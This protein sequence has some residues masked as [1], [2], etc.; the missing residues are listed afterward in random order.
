MSSSGYPQHHDGSRGNWQSQQQPQQIRTSPYH[1]VVGQPPDGGASGSTNSTSNS[2][3]SYSPPSYAQQHQPYHPHHA[4]THGQPVR[5]N[6]HFPSSINQHTS[7]N[8]QQQ[9]QQQAQLQH[10]YAQ[11]RPQ[12]VVQAA[13][14]LPYPAHDTQP[15]SYNNNRDP[16]QTYQPSYAQQSLFQPSNSPSNHHQ[17]QQH[18]ASPSHNLYLASSYPQAS[19]LNTSSTGNN[20]HCTTTATAAAGLHPLLAGRRT[21]TYL[22]AS[23]QGGNQEQ[24]QLHH[25]RQDTDD[26]LMD[27]FKDP[28]IGALEHDEIVSG[29]PLPLEHPWLDEFSLAV[30]EIALEPM[31]GRQLH[32]RIESQLEAIERN[33]IPCVQ[34]L[35]QCQQELR[36]A[37]QL[38]NSV[39]SQRKKL[40]SLPKFHQLFVQTLPNKF[41]H[42]QSW[43]NKSRNPQ[44][45]QERNL[46][47]QELKQLSNDA[48]KVAE[49]SEAQLS[50]NY[51]SVKAA[52]LGG[53]REGE[54][55]GLRKWL[56]KHG[57]GLQICTDLECILRALND[58]DN[59][60]N[61]NKLAHLFRPSTQHTL[62]QL[63]RDIPSSYQERSAAHPYLPF[64]HRMEEALRRLSTFDPHDDG[65]ICLV[66]SDDDSP[67]VVEETPSN[68]GVSVRK[69]HAAGDDN[70]KKKR[71]VEMFHLDDC[72][73][74][75]DSN[76]DPQILNG[77]SA[78][79]RYSETDGSSSSG[80]SEDEKVE[81][82]HQAESQKDSNEIFNRRNFHQVGD[83]VHD[84]NSNNSSPWSSLG[85]EKAPP[86]SVPLVW[87]VA[88]DALNHAEKLAHC[89]DY[90]A[91]CF[92]SGKQQTV[93]PVTAPFDRFWDGRNYATIMRLLS[94]ILRHPNV[95]VFV[96][97]IQ[98]EWLK[99]DG[100]PPFSKRVEHPISLSQ[101]VN[102]LA[103]NPA[104]IPSIVCN[105]GSLPI[106]TL[107]SWN[108]WR[109]KDLIMAVDLVFLNFL[110]YSYLLGEERTEIRSDANKMRLILWNGVD[111][112]IDRCRGDELW[113]YDVMPVKR[114]F[115][116]GFVISKSSQ[117]H[118]DGLH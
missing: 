14:I 31:T 63:R 111:S 13:S 101:V 33:Y 42:K 23:S 69:R 57:K 85:D 29:P 28:V 1:T 7:P 51:E 90:I 16:H 37:V 113:R 5:I 60:V 84:G 40:M 4:L 62:H 109:G 3:I 43:S 61:V 89:L 47:F 21:P 24:Q 98:D 27:L 32:Q 70:P 107:S 75:P 2:R 77:D 114:K 93:R 41:Y 18:Y 112:I 95:G 35:V 91:G 96:N 49:T 81:I 20:I 99:R 97:P 73:P 56:S 79:R 103:T 17:Q 117:G 52:F 116:S 110:G 72:E 92:D 65:V 66:D 83:I 82:I 78:S 53:M 55:W 6:H 58:K 67:Q 15:H 94:Q 38:S 64:F 50:R 104:E 34:F 68:P 22:F 100:Y 108:M 115:T 46:A 105:D 71:S 59:K 54:S 76:V 106:E 11:S 45:L 19:N 39:S 25:R 102:A 118:P 12:S 86:P 30:P 87:P 10:P 48:Q 8:Y 26:F 88:P 74:Q 36:R 80:E 9:Q 44:H